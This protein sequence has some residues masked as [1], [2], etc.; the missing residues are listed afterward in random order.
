MG[1]ERSPYYSV[2]VRQDLCV[3]LV[4]KALEQGCRTLDVGEKESE[5][6]REK[7]VRC[8]DVPRDLVGEV[9][10]RQPSPQLPVLIL[11]GS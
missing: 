5:R 9:K 3:R 10:D 1:G 4:A 2:V 11:I 8:G 6:L 7:T